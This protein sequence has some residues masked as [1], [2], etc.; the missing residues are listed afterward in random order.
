M[1]VIDLG[2]TVL[3][4][5]TDLAT[6]NP[7]KAVENIRKRMEDAISEIRK[8]GTPDMLNKLNMELSR[9][10]AAGGMD[11]IIP[12]EGIVFKFKDKVMKLTGSFAPINQI[13][14]MT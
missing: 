11:R 13:T 10:Q 9:L 12:E 3:M 8:K 5:V 14:N 1:L 4:N 2:T 7:S 6:V